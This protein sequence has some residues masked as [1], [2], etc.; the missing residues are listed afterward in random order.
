MIPTKLYVNRV[1]GRHTKK[2]SK[3]SENLRRNGEVGLFVLAPGTAVQ[4]NL[5]LG[6][7]VQEQNLPGQGW[8]RNLE[9]ELSRNWVFGDNGPELVIANRSIGCRLWRTYKRAIF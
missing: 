5:P 2:R 4:D 7:R 6:L 3:S 8:H 1:A 9:V